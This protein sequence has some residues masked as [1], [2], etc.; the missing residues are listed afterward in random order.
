MQKIAYLKKIIQTDKKKNLKNKIQ[1]LKTALE[2]FDEIIN[3]SKPN[4][5]ILQMII[6]KIYILR[7]KT[8]RFKLKSDIEKLN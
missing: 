6:N 1:K 8:I 2:Y 7:D 4:R 5:I 3:T